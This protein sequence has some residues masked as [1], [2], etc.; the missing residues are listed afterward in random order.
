MK[1]LIITEN[2]RT[3]GLETQI[4]GFCRYLKNSGHEV[5]LISGIGSRTF[6]LKE[7]IDK[8]ILEV[9]MRPDLPT[10]EAIDSINRTVSFIKDIDPDVLHLH[11]FTS[12][13]YGGIGAAVLQKP[14][15]ITLHGPLSLTYG[16]NPSYRLY[17]DLILKDA[18]R[19]F[20]VSEEVAQRVKDIVPDCN[21]SILP[22]GVDTE[23]FIPVQRDPDGPV[24]LVARIDSDKI[25][26]IKSFLTEWSKLPR[27]LR[28][29]IHIFGEGNSVEELKNWVKAN[30]N[31]GTWV[32]FMGHEDNL[33]ERL[34]RGYSLVA[35]MGRVVLEAAAMNL[36]VILV[37]YSR[38]NGPVSVDNCNQLFYRN[39]SGRYTSV[40]NNVEKLKEELSELETSPERF[41][42]RS[43]VVEN[44]DEKKIH[45]GYLQEVKNAKQVN[46]RWREAFLSS[47][48]E[49]EDISL[50]GD[51][52][53]HCLLNNLPQDQVN[54]NWVNLFLSDKINWA[55]TEKNSLGSQLNQTIAEKDSLQH[56]FNQMLVEKEALGSQ[57]N[58][59]IAEKDSLWNQLNNIYTSDFWKAASWYYRV[60]DKNPIL[61]FFYLNAKK[62]KST[63]KNKNY[64]F[65]LSKFQN[66]S[67]QYGIRKALKMTFCKLTNSSFVTE[68]ERGTFKEKDR[69]TDRVFTDIKRPKAKTELK[70]IIESHKHVKGV[71]LYKSFL[72]W[73]FPL[74]QRPHQLSIAFAKNG[75][76]VFY[77]SPNWEYDN[78]T[79][80]SKIMDNLL[81]FHEDL[82]IFN[83]IDN[84]IVFL[85]WNA[86]DDL[87]PFKKPKMI[88]YDYLDHIELLDVYNE[89]ILQNHIE[90][91]KKADIVT[92][93][94]ED[95]YDEVKQYR[96]K[97]ILCPNAADVEHFRNSKKEIPHDIKRLVESK[98][99]IIGYYGALARWFDYE[100]LK[101][102]ASRKPNYNFLLIGYDY[103]GS[104]KKSGIH[105]YENVI[106][107]DPVHYSVLPQYLQYF[108][109][110]TISFVVDDITSATSPI[111][112]FEYAALRKP[113]VTTDLPECRKYRAVLISHSFEEFL[114][115]IDRALKLKDDPDYLKELDKLAED[116]TWD[117]RVKLIIDGIEKKGLDRPWE[118]VQCRQSSYDIINFPIMP[119]DSRIQRSQQLIRQF[120]KKG[121]R[122][123]R[124]NTNFSSNTYSLVKIDANVFH[125]TLDKDIKLNIFTDV[126]DD[127]NLLR[128]IH[129]LDVF[130]RNEFIPAPPIC[131]VELPFWS[132]IAEYL[133]KRYNC[134]IIY[135]C[136][137]E[138]SGFSTNSEKMLEFEKELAKLSDAIIVSSKKLFDKMKE[139]NNQTIVINNATDFD[140]FHRLKENDLLKDYKK[141][142][143]GYFGAISDWFDIE[144]IEYA[145]KKKEDW[146]F[147]LIGSTFG[148]DISRATKLSNIHFLGEKP[149]SELSQYLYWFDVCLIPMKLNKLTE[150]TNPV[151]FF[152]YI[153][154]GKPVVSAKLLELEP[155]GDILYFYKTKEDFVLQTEKALEEKDLNLIEKRIDIARQNTWEKRFVEFDQLIRNI[156]PKVSIILITYNC[157]DFTKLCINSIYT[158][159]K[160]PNFEIIIVD[161]C[162]GDGT[163]EYLKHLLSQK[164]NVKVIFN[165]KNYGFAYANNQGIKLVEGEYVIFLNN[166]TVVSPGWIYRLLR[167]L[168][169]KK[170]GMVGPVT[171]SSGNKA[172]ITVS[173]NVKT[174]EGFD[175]FTEKYLRDH[176]ES[177]FF[178]IKM[179]GLYCVAMRKGVLDEVGVLDE[180]F[181]IGSFED[182]DFANRVKLR[183]Y[184]IICARD[185]FIHHFG[186][187]TFGKLAT[188]E[189][190]SIYNRNKLKFEEKWG[191]RW[192]PDLD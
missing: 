36:P 184:R 81:V 73:N 146:T 32:T 71:I 125:L 95:L 40:I 61:R 120:A 163:V 18:W 115:N 65:Y 55:I 35:G 27:S 186:S 8:N 165:E 103:D 112:L 76:L 141:P 79:G 4:M 183:G 63:I 98:K 158:N 43:W 128:M 109:V 62:F 152:E 91:I 143:V 185:I 189:L 69:N 87:A 111:K 182:D 140:H 123:F 9:D 14:Y 82:D 113:I 11:P 166:D 127:V 80:F 33:H 51:K 176:P 46:Y 168:E 49:A 93:T 15:V 25:P 191:S 23:R 42:L 161:N 188:Q 180:R 45:A 179:L 1:I 178:E 16:Y 74:F 150:A 85:N 148:A 57:L 100:L 17:I 77:Y 173:Y 142:I 68:S 157:L 86:F 155:Y 92:V 105:L 172:Q 72:D 151:K 64:L 2:F 135:D 22:N 119:W 159:S 122:I 116:N 156:F 139:L 136:M 39:F 28:Q 12:I 30:L 192:E 167:H 160:Y 70:N 29:T 110:A 94:A 121:S 114:N 3:G 134:K 53:F 147:I 78:Y 106:R 187:A 96:D 19:V 177:E 13:I 181:S 52:V 108:D 153:S 171:N 149:Y 101:Y 102:C 104:Y 84:Y 26:G 99:P 130:F 10:K 54:S 89:K 37:G 190:Q 97:V 118:T 132:S 67:K 24:A 7:I 138:H 58:Q 107:I 47:I 83:S 50:F 126:I 164:D 56:Q 6:P 31:G 145:A 129:S 48:G 162:S 75:F 137:D 21:L 34:K 88:I 174:L 175:K 169:S 20:C 144:T 59:T 170:V 41:L 124:I 131:I 133:K 66:Y 154:S 5:Y 117:S 60:R 44:A 38:P 90:T